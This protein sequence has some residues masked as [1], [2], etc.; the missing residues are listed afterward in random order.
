MSELPEIPTSAAEPET[1]VAFVDYFRAVA[2]RKGEGLEADEFR[3]TVGASTL[4]IGGILKHLAFVEDWWWIAVWQGADLPDPWTAEHFEDP[5]WDFHSAA[6]DTPEQILA[7]YDDRVAAAR[8]LV[9]GLLDDPAGLDAVA[10]KPRRG[11]PVNLRWILTHLIEEE[12][13]HLGHADLLREA[14]DG[15]VG[16]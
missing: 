3:R 7:L 2:R 6:E 10:A 12:A 4:T 9:A 13:R 14:I 5:D 11:Q 1:L 15:A 16:D 8:V